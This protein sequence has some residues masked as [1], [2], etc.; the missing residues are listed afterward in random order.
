MHTRTKNARPAI[1][2]VEDDPVNQL[3]ARIMLGS[4]GH[5]IAGMAATGVEAVAACRQQQF[6]LILMDCEM[7][8]MNGLDTTARLRSM[9]ISTPIVAFT[10]S[11]SAYNRERCLQAGMD[12]FLD[13]PVQLPAFAATIQRWL[14]A[15]GPGAHAGRST[16]AHG[17][18]P[19]RDPG[20]FARTFQGDEALFSRALAAFERQTG[21]SLA[22]LGDAIGAGDQ[23]RARA[24]AHRVRGGAAI[25]GA[26]LLAHH[27]G[28]IEHASAW[29]AVH[30]RDEA[31]GAQ[32]AYER[33][34]E[35]CGSAG[36]TRPPD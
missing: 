30:Q 17:E 9:G 7:P 22:L 15:A 6:D 33:F 10:A 16:P 13:K 18:P 2:V 4:L 28:V 5:A 21:L 35:A 24:L 36:S 34:L 19:D 25:L 31:L 23:E 3:A 27:C 29:D 26:L 11:G 1:L 20:V 32:R 8:Q 12:D 14:G